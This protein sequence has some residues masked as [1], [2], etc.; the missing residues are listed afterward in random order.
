MKYYEGR[1]LAFRQVSFA[2][3]MLQLGIPTS[4]KNFKEQVAAGRW[5]LRGMTPCNW[6]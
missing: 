3:P 6:Q 4:L 1:N 2:T 5:D